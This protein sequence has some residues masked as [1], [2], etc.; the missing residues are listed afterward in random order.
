[1]SNWRDIILNEFPTQV[2]R[3]TLV[4]DP[5][6][7]LSEEGVLQGLRKK[8]FDLIEFEDPIA[9]RYAYESK[10]R[11]VWD[12][13][14]TTDL[15][16]VLRSREQD[17]RK[18]PYDLYHAG[19]K[20][21]FN[22]PAIFPNMS[23]PVVEAL[24]AAQFD[25]LYH[26]QEQY[27]PGR[28]GSNQTADFILLHVFETE[29]KLICT[30]AQ[31]LHFLM[32]RH[33]QEKIMP[34]RMV[35]R[36]IDVLRQG[37]RFTEWPLERIVPNRAD[38]YAFVQ[39]RWAWRVQSELQAKG[40]VVEERKT[41]YGMKI[42]GPAELPF[43]HDDVRVYLDTLFNE[44]LL[45]PVTLSPDTKLADVWLSV[46]VSEGTESEHQRRIEHAEERAVGQ[47][48]A[49]DSSYQEWL[50]YARALGDLK[51]L[52][53]LAGM[54]RPLPDSVEAAQASFSPWLLDR[55]GSLYN[56]PPMPPVMVHHIPK[57]ISGD[58]SKDSC[59]RVALLVIDGM[60]ISQWAVIREILRTQ[61][62]TIRYEEQALF[63]WIPTL[64]SVS[65][66][67]L[68]SGKLPQF[69]PDSFNTTSKERVLWQQFWAERGIE[70][71]AVQYM[72]ALSPAKESEFVAHLEDDRVR[73]LGLVVNTLDEIMHGMVLGSSG[74]YNQVEQWVR[75]GYLRS[76]LE[77]LL[78]HG[79]FV[80]IAS[81]HGN[82][83][84]CGMGNPAEGAI[85]ETRGQ[86]VRIYPA[87]DLRSSVRAAYPDAVPWPRTGLPPDV[88]PLLA[89]AGKAFTKE[90][91]ITVSHG[92]SSVEEV[93]VPYVRV[94]GE[95]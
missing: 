59:R 79:F 47:Q 37:D 74:M 46:G 38:F 56:Q 21:S 7:L 87:Q 77:R 81:D 58:L 39:E 25:A 64:T 52:R 14:Q 51:G 80:Y 33:Y 53:H 91:E 84:A 76:V 26:A 57:A 10:Y 1:M 11:T 35:S 3:L 40:P 2:A 50:A 90:G 44:G 65:R 48:P 73:I 41:R 42:S 67:A 92:G 32:R 28:M 86:R 60:S 15:V 36:F 93:I 78:S 68:F 89:P 55:Y 13:G 29:P 6:G 4:A 9:F 45:Q 17:L 95:Q 72:A 82:T 18:L 70:G 62:E 71:N 75:K 43:E 20:L 54:D 27:S 23:Y 83:E 16:V 12:Q 30:P 22:I 24:G 94:V 61:N 49:T 34:E 5:D 8:G 19:R 31:L 88:F 85:A 66:Q 63:A 69:F